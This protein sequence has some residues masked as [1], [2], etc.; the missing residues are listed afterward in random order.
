MLLISAQAF[1][2]T[3]ITGIINTYLPVTLITPGAGTCDAAGS[4]SFTLSSVAGLSITPGA[5]GNK[6]LI[7]QMQAGGTGAVNNGAAHKF[8]STYGAVTN[9]GGAGNYEFAF[10]STIVGS[11]ITFT[12]PLVNTYD[13]TGKVQIIPVVIYPSGVTTTGV[14]TGQAWNGTTGGVLLLE[15]PSLALNHNFD[16]LGKGFA[17]GVTADKSSA[18]CNTSAIDLAG[19]RFGYYFDETAS[20]SGA[21]CSS[22]NALNYGNDKGGGIFPLITTQRIGRGAFANAGG[23][24]SGHNSGGGGGGNGGAGGKGGYEYDNC[25]AEVTDDMGGIGG[26]AVP[27]GATAVFMGGGGGAGHGNNAGSTSGANGGG[28]IIL[29]VTT[30]NATVAGLKIEASGVK[31]AS[32]LSDGAGGG[33]AGGSILL[34]VTT[35]SGS[36]MSVIANGGNGGDN[37]SSGTCHAVGGGGGGG[38]IKTSASIPITGVT[39]SSASGTAG[40]FTVAGMPGTCGTYGSSNGVSSTPS[41]GLVLNQ[42]GCS[43]P[44]EFLSFIAIKSSENSVDLSWNTASE[45]DNAYFEIM[46]SSDGLNWE[47]IETVPAKNKPSAYSATDKNLAQGVYYYKIRQKD[48]SGESAFSSVISVNIESILKNLI[49]SPNPVSQDESLSLSVPAGVIASFTIT[50]LRGV[51]ICR[52][53]QVYEST[54]TLSLKEVPDGCYFINVI[55]ADGQHLIS[56]MIVR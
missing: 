7:I 27:N 31:P 22:G 23:G 3:N 41:A 46:R 25:S 1:A 33:G 11:V 47:L 39:L 42:Q 14:V 13:E 26:Y 52:N 50:D 54:T 29:N 37:S 36:A 44:V 24:G 10:I 15:A 18:C 49:I 28:I 38:Y 19:N 20:G 16:M 17:G 21:G 4:P 45:I 48:R 32:A 8:A 35:F 40:V 51:V 5:S 43:L 34:Q 6:V 12:K 55:T 30:V 56:K 9:Y 2:Q 53:S